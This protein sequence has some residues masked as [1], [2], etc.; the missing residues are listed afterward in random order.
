MPHK[1]LIYRQADLHDGQTA[2]TIKIAFR[3][4][5]LKRQQL[6]TGTKLRFENQDFFLFHYNKFFEMSLIS[7]PNRVQT[8]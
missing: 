1:T 6:S 4:T 5:F 7:G 8:C 2:C 3:V